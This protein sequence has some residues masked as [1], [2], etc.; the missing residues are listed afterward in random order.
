MCI[1]SS[2][3]Y[4][5]LSLRLHDAERELGSLVCL[6]YW[7]ENVMC[8]IGHVSL[9]YHKEGVVQG[10]EVMQTSDLPS[11]SQSKPGAKWSPEA[12]ASHAHSVL[13][14]LQM[15]CERD[16]ATYILSREAGSEDIALYEVTNSL[17][18]PSEESEEETA[19][20]DTDHPGWQADLI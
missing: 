5:S 11:L 3:E 17:L 15:N 19:E 6:D 13:R 7:L 16:G 10:Y 20:I 9:C 12:V 1:W 14:F 2:E 4:P 18:L 8:N